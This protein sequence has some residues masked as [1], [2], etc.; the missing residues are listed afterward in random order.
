[1]SDEII[2]FQAPEP[3]ALSKLLSG[4]DVSSLIAQGGMGAV[5]H[6]VQSSLERD[7]AIKLLPKE[8]GDE[9][10]KEQF[11][12]E[13]KAMAKLNHP[14]L[15]GIYDFGEIE[16]M[17]YIVM[18][19]VEGN[20]LYYSCYQKAIEQSE[21][22]RLVTEIC[23]GLAHAHKNGIVHRD[24]KPANI[25]LDSDAHVKIGDFGLASSSE[26]S[27]EGIVYGTPGYAAPEIMTDAG[28]M[29]ISSDIFAVGVILHE[30]LTGKLPSDDPR[31]PSRQAKC[32]P[33][34][35][36]IVRKATRT[37][38]ESRY[39]S[40]EEMVVDLS[41]VPALRSLKT[42]AAAPKKAA[43]AQAPP[44]RQLHVAGTVAPP[45]DSGSSAAGIEAPPVVM[46]I[47]PS[48]NWPLIRN[49]MIIALLIPAL[50][51]AWGRFKDKEEERK[52]KTA[53][54]KREEN[55][56]EA[57]RKA[58]AEKE[59]RAMEEKARLV[60]LEKKRKKDEAESFAKEVHKAPKKTPREQLAELR[61]ELR[62]GSR[63][64]FPERTLKRGSEHFFFVEE[65]M[66]WSMAAQFAEDHG[67]H[68]ATP[69]GASDL[70]WIG[71]NQGEYR[72][73]WIG[74]GA[75]GNNDWG[76]VTGEEW[77]H[78][79]PLTNIGSCAAVTTTGV[80]GAR[81]NGEKLP[82]F[83][84][85]SADGVNAG[86]LDSQLERLK[87]TLGAPT[88]AW[89]PGTVFSQGRAYLLVNRSVAWEEADLVAG[90][91]GGHLAV[92]SG[93]VEKDFIRETLTGGL[94]KGE[95]AWLGGRRAN[96]GAWTWT[97]REVWDR[98]DWASSSPDGGPRAT[99]LRFISN[100][101]ASGWDDAQPG[102]DTAAQAF[103]IEWSDDF[104]SAPADGVVGDA[105]AKTDEIVKLR[106]VAARYLRKLTGEH[107]RLVN[108][109]R[110][111]FI[112]DINSWI[113]SLPKSKHDQWVNRI[114]QIR[115][116]IPGLGSIPKDL[117]IQGVPAD[118]AEDFNN[119]M[120]RQ[121]R[122]DQTLEKDILKFRSAYLGKLASARKQA[123]DAGFKEKLP[124]FD[125]EI[126]AIGD[127]AKAFLSHFAM[128]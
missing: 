27:E 7:V 104:K 93:V 62:G 2:T 6:A 117:P 47:Q 81:P 1:M 125:Q 14:N 119:A 80:L 126:E 89:P 102:D 112:W 61:G 12:T 29:G 123:E 17:P 87:G 58:K 50:I 124:S 73:S 100:D 15:I 71:K 101:D 48:T 28:S 52:L 113:R 9:E 68:L 4:Y 20:S 110:K 63:S 70:S 18:E 106:I 39:S 42:E 30:L 22:V 45:E 83:I 53:E 109:N 121:N 127:D 31:P 120:A 84:Q 35:D 33:Q 60:A 111:N 78:Q 8:F 10:F 40:A 103:L 88:P 46:A 92:S 23:H 51:F 99:A 49:L 64:A 76:W 55:A 75:V 16:G 97:T 115:E 116:A 86:S 11:A 77:K 90:A 107:E 41:K 67:G 34:L 122:F 21:A 98:P 54:Q 36:R 105:G 32:H 44:K 56:A 94:G 74:G 59:R 3:K 69:L 24:I 13:A 108:A 38:P 85:W 66:T 96:D 26:Q 25:L 95:A 5:Y 82:F 128:D 114:H 37:N 43:V 57:L 91:S 65:P 118:L 72:R 19:F 79:K